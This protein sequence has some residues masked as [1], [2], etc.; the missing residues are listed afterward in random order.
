[1]SRNKT[2]IILSLSLIAVAI[3]SI[4]LLINMNSKI[5]TLESQNKKLMAT[6]EELTNGENEVKLYLLQY[7]YINALAKMNTNMAYFKTLGSDFES[8]LPYSY[9][10]MIPMYPSDVLETYYHDGMTLVD[11]ATVNFE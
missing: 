11:T 4:I 10:D 2:V 5:D 3:I 1:M 8:Y 9:D 7:Y 6:N